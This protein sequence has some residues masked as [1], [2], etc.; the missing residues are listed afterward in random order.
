MSK[1]KIQFVTTEVFFNRAL[2][3]SKNRFIAGLKKVFD[4][5]EW[6][7][8]NQQKSYIQNYLAL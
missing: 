6:N 1:Q 4:K 5:F 3:F 8:T 7:I 2:K